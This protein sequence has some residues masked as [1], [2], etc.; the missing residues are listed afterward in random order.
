M[1]N[2]ERFPDGVD[3]FECGQSLSLGEGL[4]WPENGE[5]ILCSYC[6]KEELDE[7]REENKQLKQWV[8]D[9]Q[10]GMYINCVYCGYRHGFNNSDTPLIGAAALTQHVENCPKHPM[11]KLK[12]QYDALANLS[13]LG[14]QHLKEENKTLQNAQRR[15]K[16][17][18]GKVR[19]NAARMHDIIKKLRKRIL[20][21]G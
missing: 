16:Y 5:E 13:L 21:D 17:T 14:V 7:L 19:K 18:L 20:S 8:D 11:S 15:T 12:K 6:E 2:E 1:G 9:L 4:E 10:S 3:C